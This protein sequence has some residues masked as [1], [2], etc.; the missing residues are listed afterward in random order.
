MKL[1]FWFRT[2]QK[3]QGLKVLTKIHRSMLMF[4]TLQI[5][6]YIV[7]HSKP[8]KC[9]KHYKIQMKTQLNPTQISLWHSSPPRTR[10]I[11]EIIERFSNHFSRNSAKV[12]VLLYLIIPPFKFFLCVHQQCFILLKVMIITSTPKPS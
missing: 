6:I 1:T 4:R 10:K 11:Q 7:V 3:F 2:L 9:W 8:Y 12:F 5:L